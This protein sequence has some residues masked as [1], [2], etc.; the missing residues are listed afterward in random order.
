MKDESERAMR[1][2]FEEMIA[3][4]IDSDDGFEIG[5]RDPRFRLLMMEKHG[6]LWRWYEDYLQVV[7]VYGPQKD[8][9]LKAMY[10]DPIITAF[11][12]KYQNG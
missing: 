6:M 3:F 12:E 5:L 2:L 1:V 9:L 10:A 11:L 7:K 4:G 8:E